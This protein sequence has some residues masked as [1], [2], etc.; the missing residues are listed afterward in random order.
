M[1][2][3][4]YAIRWKVFRRL[5]VDDALVLV[6][7][8]MLLANAVI[9]ERAKDNLF[10]VLSVG[11]ARQRPPD[12]L[13]HVDVLRQTQLAS[14]LLFLFSLWCIKF[15]FLAFFYRLG[16]NIKRQKMLWWCVL[17]LNAACLVVVVG[18]RHYRCMAKSARENLSECFTSTSLPWCVGHD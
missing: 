1:V 12:F 8:L 18:I 2:V 3:C 4:R 17:A 10:M 16:E 13:D 7:W 9:L 15:S 14:G 6:A 5:F 11:A